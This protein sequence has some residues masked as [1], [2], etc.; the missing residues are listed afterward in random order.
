MKKK[1]RG[2]YGNFSCGAAVI[3]MP[4]PR[5]Q[6]DSPDRRIGAGLFLFIEKFKEH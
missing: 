1:F 6:H 5:L 2:D 3:S 4:I